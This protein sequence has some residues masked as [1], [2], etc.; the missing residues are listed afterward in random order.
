MEREEEEIKNRA[1]LRPQNDWVKSIYT[2]ISNIL[3]FIV[4]KL[5]N[6]ACEG[7]EMH[8]V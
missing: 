4:L 6:P 8:L 2:V 7:S 1:F 3:F 5:L